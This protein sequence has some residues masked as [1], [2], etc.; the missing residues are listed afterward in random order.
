MKFAPAFTAQRRPITQLG[1]TL[2]LALAGAAGLLSLIRWDAAPRSAWAAQPVEASIVTVSY[3]VNLPVIARPHVATTE[4]PNCRFGVGGSASTYP[5]TALNVGWYMNWGAQVTPF[6]P[7][8]VD[9]VQVVRVRPD[10]NGYAIAPPTTTLALIAAKNPGA[11]WLIGN[12]PDA[13]LQDNMP[14]ALYA[15]AYHDVYHWLK[16]ADPGAQ[17]GA[18]SIVQPTPLRLQYLDL[19][20]A[21]Y[22][23][24][25]AAA[26][27]ADVWSIHSYILRELDLTDPEACVSFDNCTEPPYLPWGAYI[28]PGLT[29]T[30]GELY[31]FSAM[32]SRQI[33][34][35]RLIDFRVWLRDRG[36]RHTPL[37]ITEYGTLFPYPPYD[38]PWYDEFGVELTEA[39]TAQFMTQTFADLL[40]LT[41]AEL[42][43]PPDENRL[44]QRWL[45]YSLDDV[46]YGG[47][48]FD[49]V[50]QARRPLGD[51][52]AATTH[53]LPPSVE[54]HP[55]RV[56]T[57]PAALIAP[58]GGHVSPT[59][60]VAVINSG[61]TILTQTGWLR[62]TDVTGG[63]ANW[64]VDQPLA[65][66]T[67]C[68][69]AR[70]VTVTWPALTTGTHTL[71]VEV[72]PFDY[73]AEPAESNNVITLTVV[74][75]THALYLPA[76]SR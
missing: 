21:A 32:F 44:V 56:W 45:W 76:T 31:S 4:Y 71:R 51:A 69:T 73:W 68:G 35:Q 20:L 24:N 28:P 55:D 46:A 57:D 13:P 9:Y 15:Q 54:L 10:E 43:Y 65:P 29:A 16:Q 33:F 18:G 63:Q 17:I 27:P 40:T 75:G 1:L 70:T 8:G 41:D 34:R 58:V 39:R 61:N 52:Y 74:V 42:G 50:S 22:R 25:Y 47:P 19:V 11:L 26:L 67:G 30:R 2:L 53:A 62:F 14:P 48:L 64:H 59:V 12:E 60:N 23:A 72:D 49:P 66:F 5:I 38:L 7:V 6:E 36:Y 3:T 37:I